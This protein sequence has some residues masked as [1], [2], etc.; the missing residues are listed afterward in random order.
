MLIYKTLY[1]HNVQCCWDELNKMVDDDFT[2]DRTSDVKPSPH[3]RIENMTGHDGPVSLQTG[4][5]VIE[6]F[7]DEQP[8]GWIFL[9]KDLPP[10]EEIGG[11]LVNP[12][13]KKEAE[14]IG[15][16]LISRSILLAEKSNC[17]IFYTTEWKN[18]SNNKKNSLVQEYGVIW[19]RLYAKYGFK[20]AIIH[21]FDKN[22]VNICLFNLSQSSC[23]NDFMLSHPLSILS[24][25]GGEIGYNGGLAYEMKWTDLQT[26][27]FLAFYI[28]GKREN[29]MP[30]IIGVSQKVGGIAFDAH[31]NDAS[32]VNNLGEGT[33][34]VHLVNHGQEPL[35]TYNTFL[36]PKGITID[37]DKL[38]N[39]ISE[40]RSGKEKSYEVSYCIEPHFKKPKVSSNT[41]LITWQLYIE[42]LSTYQVSTGI[43][44]DNVN[45][46]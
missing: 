39:A 10:Y 19:Q 7:R 33:F 29:V 23:Y 41:V 3:S 14:A 34:K 28:E 5:R 32:A 43:R 36:A 46:L 45:L 37:K 44:M 30:K 31:I 38:S 27:D 16:E 9:D 12:K 24:I 35:V 2:P 40:I 18:S 21:N 26:D 4:S 11:L 1:Y 8:V 42:N 17:N 20:P 25:S 22:D 6:A 13:Y 15:E